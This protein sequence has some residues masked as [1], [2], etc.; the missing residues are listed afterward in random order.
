MDRQFISIHGKFVTSQTGSFSR[1]DINYVFCYDLADV[2]CELANN[3]VG[4]LLAQTSIWLR[5]VLGVAA[6]LPP[7]GPNYPPK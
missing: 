6:K 7:R 2:N 3:F 5:C 1:M 4:W